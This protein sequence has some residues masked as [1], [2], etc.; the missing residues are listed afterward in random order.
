MLNL[1]YRSIFGCSPSMDVLKLWDVF[2]VNN[3]ILFMNKFHKS[4]ADYLQIIFFM[5]T[6]FNI[7]DPDSLA[8]KT[9]EQNRRG[10]DFDTPAFPIYI[11]FTLLMLKSV[12]STTIYMASNQD[13]RVVFGQ[14]DFNACVQC[15][16]WATTVSKDGH[17]M[18]DSTDL[19]CFIS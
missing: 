8:L 5:D 1:R 14:P 16:K 13:N 10:S 6:V 3:L 17:H 7:V 18:D 4:W 19:Q 11:F 15:R 12:S 2:F 9:Q